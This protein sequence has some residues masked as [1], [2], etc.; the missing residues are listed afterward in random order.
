MATGRKIKGTLEDLL[1]RHGAIDEL[2]LKH[3]REEQARSGGELGRV[4]VSVGAISE[5]LL[6]RILAHQRGLPLVD[7]ARMDIEQAVL[8]A[9]PVRV[10]ELHHVIPVGTDP[11]TG[12]IEI[13]TAQP[14]DVEHLRDIEVE[15][16]I[17]ALAVVAT[18]AAIA[19]G[20]RRHYYGD[21]PERRAPP[22][23]ITEA[24]LPEAAVEPEVEPEPEAVLEPDPAGDQ[25]RRLTE[26]LDWM[27]RTASQTH[28]ASILA[29]LDRLEQLHTHALQALRGISKLLV[30]VGF[31]TAEEV[32]ERTG[33][34]LEEPPAG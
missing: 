13:A 1:L 31:A 26:R 14:E 27:E 7:P 24:D 29:R 5:A 21:A 3:A 18:T 9:I 28:M 6:L 10:C 16:E 8:E 23:R 32:V 33:V 4:L 17:T 34:P 11:A 22:Q 15:C 20:I 12:A 19:R 25:L 30:D 2:Q